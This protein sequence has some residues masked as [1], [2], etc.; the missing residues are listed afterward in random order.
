MDFPPSVGGIQSMLSGLAGELRNWDLSVVAPAFPGDRVFDAG[1][2]YRVLRAPSFGSGGEGMRRL[3]GIVARTIAD[4]IAHS[5]DVILIG[6][7]ALCPLGTFLHRTLRRPFVLISYD[8]EY[9]NSRLRRWLPSSFRECVGVVTIS[10]FNSRIMQALG[11]PEDKIRQLTLGFDPGRFSDVVPSDLPVRLGITGRP[12]VLTVARLADPFKGVD[13]MLRAWPQVAS[14][15]PDARYVVAGDGRHRPQLETLAG[16]LNLGESVIFTG[17][18]SD[19]DL[20]ALYKECTAFALM[21][22]LREGDGGAEGFGL[23]FLEANSFGKPVLGGNSG[24][25]PDAVIDEVTGLLAEPEDVADVARQTIRLLTDPD[26]AARLGGQGRARV[27]NDLTWSASAARLEGIVG[28]V[29]GRG[30]ST[31]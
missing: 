23:V 19:A 11:C 12:T 8:V 16:E 22:R 10:R 4:A 15:V 26:L 24:G 21:S 29:L 5:P 2:R 6:H 17:K 30:A 14:V 13:T 3:P 7:A 27:L 25:I 9:Q 18:I 31:H 28:E 1:L 20:A